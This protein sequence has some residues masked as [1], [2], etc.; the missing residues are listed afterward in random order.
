M[1]SFTPSFLPSF[2]P[3]FIYSFTHSFMKL[4]YYTCHHV[5]M[6]TSFFLEGISI[7]NGRDRH[8]SFS[9]NLHLFRPVAVKRS[10]S[11]LTNS[12]SC[13]PQTPILTPMSPCTRAL[14]V[15][16]ILIYFVTWNYF[17]CPS[18]ESI[19]FSMP[20]LADFLPHYLF[21]LFCYMRNDENLI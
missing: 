17:L 16:A 3:S 19:L 8:D 15:P 9:T 5:T 1:Y 14:S 13:L 4:L 12:I 10:A 11:L 6:P 7:H 2:L 18:Y 21:S 20:L